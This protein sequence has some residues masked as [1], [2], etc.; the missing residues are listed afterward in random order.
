MTKRRKRLSP[1]E[2]VCKLQTADRLRAEGKTGDEIAR[3][4]GVSQPTYYNWRSRYG[5][6]D[7]N[8]AKELN[9]LREENDELKRVVAEKEL[10]NRA[11]KEIANRN[12]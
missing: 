1:E 5:A 9:K 11:L 6:M 2:I 8:E 10:E 7:V 4:L 12:W 3:H